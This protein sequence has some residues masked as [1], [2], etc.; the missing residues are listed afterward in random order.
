MKLNTAGY[1]VE[2]SLTEKEEKDVILPLLDYIVK[3]K[4][5][6]KKRRL[7]LGISGIPGSGK[8]VFAE[9]L[10]RY[11]NRRRKGGLTLKQAR[12]K[13]IEND[14]PNAEIIS[15]TRNEADI[16][17]KKNLRHRYTRLIFG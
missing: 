14:Y 16:I 12:A 2:V 4:E 1:M 5:R 6:L 17:V 3:I 7:L 11:I 15:L 13:Y 8:T 10:K 9:I